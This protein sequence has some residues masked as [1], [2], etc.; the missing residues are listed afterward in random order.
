MLKNSI[1]IIS[2]IIILASVAFSQTAEHHGISLYKQGQYAAA[3]SRLELALKDKVFKTNAELWNYLGLA[4]LGID[5]PKAARKALE[6][7]VELA[8]SNSD[9][10]A[11][12]SIAWI[13]LGK[14]NRAQQAATR[15]IDLDV[16]N[17]IAY[18]VRGTASLSEAKFDDA[19]RDALR[20]LEIHPGYAQAYALRSEILLGRLNKELRGDPGYEAITRNI[21]L[22]KEAKDVLA[23]GVARVAPADRHLIDEK[24]NG[25]TVFYDYFKKERPRPG[26]PLPDPEPGVTPPKIVVTP[27]A[28]YTNRAREAGVQGAIRVAILLAASGRVEQV[29]FLSRLGSGLDENVLTAA[30]SIRF[31]PKKIDGRPVPSVI[32]R[33]YTF[34]IY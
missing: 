9:Y 32:I 5:D 34:S 18:Y 33:E 10:H 19:D 3:A 16:N 25:L 14:M 8:P 4:R 31:E 2:L 1:S 23:E 20:A 17:A 13:R 24:L 6:K 12:L 27:M 21:G 29:L 15:A 7:A 22:M 30:R 11:N 28:R 26:A